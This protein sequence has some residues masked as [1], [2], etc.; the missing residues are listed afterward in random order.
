MQR[1]LSAACGSP[2]CIPRERE[3]TSSISQPG[4]LM[5][6]G[7]AGKPQS[8]QPGLL[9]NHCHVCHTTSHLGGHRLAHLD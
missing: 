6:G 1:L 9:P 2:Y 7:E 4:D 8:L 3:V 5:L